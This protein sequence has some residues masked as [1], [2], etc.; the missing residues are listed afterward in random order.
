MVSTN[1][2]LFKY[3]TFSIFNQ[4]LNIFINKIKMNK[5][6]PITRNDKFMSNEDYE[7]QIEMGREAIEGFGN[8]TV[9]LYRVDINMTEYDDLYGEAV[10]DGIRYFPPVELKVVP[11]LT[12]PQNKAYNSTTG[13]MRYVDDGQFIFGMYERQLEELDTQISYG[14]YIGYPINEH[15]IRFYSVV[16]DGIKNF[17]NKHT[18]MGYQAAFRTIK[19]APV[20]RSEFNGV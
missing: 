1:F 15:E 8:W 5:R 3:T 20:D 17:D 19:C 6:I 4:G 14:D 9:I 7:L 13:S 16:D 11:I 2:M 10:K 18:I 12:A